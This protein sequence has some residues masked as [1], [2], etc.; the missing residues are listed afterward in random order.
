MRTVKA[1]IE[2]GKDGAYGVYIDLENKN[3]SYGIIGDGATVQEAIE[4]FENS[5]QE[6]KTYYAEL[7]KPFEE[8]AFEFTY[9]TPSFLNYYSDILTLSGLERLTGINA[10]QLRH[11]ASGVRHP[12]PAQRQRIITGLHNLGR[13]LMTVEL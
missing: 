9:D 6:M 2:R 10:Q 1:I 11:Y 8:V 7:G 3:L 4:D 13:E 5:Y 12:R